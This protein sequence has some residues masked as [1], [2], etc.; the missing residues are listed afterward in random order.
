LKHFNLFDVPGIWSE[1]ATTCLKKLSVSLDY[2]AGAV[3]I[4]G[5]VEPVRINCMDDLTAAFKK[6]G[7]QGLATYVYVWTWVPQVPHAPYFPVLW[8]PSNNRFDPEQ[9]W[10]WWMWIFEESAKV[11]LKV[12]GDVSDGDA[13]LRRTQYELN[14]HNRLQAATMTIDHPLIFMH[15]SSVHGHQMMS[16][17]ESKTGCTGQAFV[18]GACSLMVSTTSNWETAQMP[19]CRT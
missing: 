2:E 15:I 1:D 12:I 17:Q 16:Y 3:F 5:F 6:Y 10:T 13:R 9:V 18:Q 14:K 4:E 7:A 19:A 11:G 8:L